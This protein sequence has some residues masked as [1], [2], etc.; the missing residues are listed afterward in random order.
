MPHEII[1]FSNALNQVSFGELGA[2]EQNVFF[3]ILRELQRSGFKPISFTPAEV[4]NFVGKN[5]TLKELAEISMSLR[6]TIFKK[7]FTLISEYVDADGKEIVQSDFINFFKRMTVKINRKT[8]NLESLEV[9]INEHFEFLLKELK[10]CFTVMELGE[11]LCLRRRYSK[12]LF[13]LLCQWRGT[14]KASFG[15]D[16]FKQQLD[17]PSS[18]AMCDIDKRVIKQAL[19]ELTCDDFMRQLETDNDRPTFKNLTYHKIKEGRKITRVEFTWDVEP[20]QRV[21]DA[22]PSPEIQLPPGISQEDFNQLLQ[23]HESRKAALTPI[24]PQE[25]EEGVTPEM[26][27]AV[28]EGLKESFKKP[29]PYHPSDI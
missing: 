9:E 1:R 11:F 8:G 28:T 29:L 2:L 27:A 7:D 20:G 25:L 4:R 6:E 21:I 16:Y 18:Y 5:S 12:T 14:G 23:L 10:L 26:A 13:R 24:D 17:I 22:T 3:K 19:E 15:I